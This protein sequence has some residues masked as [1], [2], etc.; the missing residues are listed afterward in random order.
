[1]LWLLPIRSTSLIYVQ[2]QIFGH[3]KVSVMDGGLPCWASCGY[4]VEKGPQPPVTKVPFTATFNPSLLR[5]LEQ[6]KQAQDDKSEQV[7]MH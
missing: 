4:P 6:V 1:M 2:L 7:G 5:N 3:E